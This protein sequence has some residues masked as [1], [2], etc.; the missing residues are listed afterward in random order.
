MKKIIIMGSGL[1][2]MY[3]ALK[4]S[5]MKD[6][7]SI[8]ITI[9]EK[10]NQ[11]GGLLSSYVHDNYCWDVGC[12]LFVR[13]KQVYLM[14][15]E[16]FIPIYPYTDVFTNNKNLPFPYTIKSIIS[17][18][19]VFRLG[20]A[21]FYYL[22][23]NLIG[24]VNKPTTAKQWFRNKMGI[25]LPNLLKLDQYLGKLQ[26]SK[27]EEIDEYLCTSRLESLDISI[28]ALYNKCKARR[29]EQ[30]HQNKN[31]EKL[32]HYCYPKGGTKT[33]SDFLFS[34]CLKNRVTFKFG[35]EVIGVKRTNNVT[36]V[37]T[38]KCTY[39]AD[40]ILSSIPL[41]ALCAAIYGKKVGEEISLQY[42]KFKNIMLLVNNIN[43]KTDTY[44]LYSFD[45]KDKWK[46]LTAL[47]QENNKYTITVEVNYLGADKNYT[48]EILDEIVV[49]LINR[50]KLFE[51]EDLLW[52][53]IRDVYSTY[54]LFKVNY[55]STLDK[56]ITN[57][58][59]KYQIYTIGRQGQYGYYNT[60]DTIKTTDE[61]LT[62]IFG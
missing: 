33:I 9:F 51:T 32:S 55:R 16:N 18:Y 56:I 43:V 59:D 20:K 26:C 54:P 62:S 50:T 37:E 8:D 57:L 58:K 25:Y 34:Q 22:L 4:L 21:L 5:E 6:N 30:K 31:S 60:E 53:G 35:E 2:G 61:V 48:D 23:G 45:T 17:S 52:K 41:N 14:N 10:E 27:L 47:K 3:A 29:T 49:G 7:S 42:T 24:L 12:Y 38:S 39:E 36:I 15:P 19:S 1:A 11:P 13:D 46:R 44:I 28:K 40:I